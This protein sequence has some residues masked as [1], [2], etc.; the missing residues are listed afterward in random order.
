MIVGVVFPVFSSYRAYE[1]YSRVAKRIAASQFRVGGV[2]VPIGQLLNVEALAEDQRQLQRLMIS[3]QKWFI[4]WVVYATIE[5]AEAVLF[6]PTLIPL[7][8]LFR[9]VVH[10]WLVVPMALAGGSEDVDK[11]FDDTEAWVEFTQLGPG[12]V[13]FGYIKPII[14]DFLDKWQ[15]E[16]PMAQVAEFVKR[17]TPDKPEE[18]K[19]SGVSIRETVDASYVMVNNL[20]DRL[21]GETTTVVDEPNNNENHDVDDAKETDTLLPDTKAGKKKKG[22][23]FW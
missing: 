6:L 21:V 18:S 7:Y 4:Y 9:L 13:Y 17:Q 10:L 3:I 2:T 8:S 12:L 16:L 15:V 11:L 14:A 5:T 23:G 22:W 19:S 20:R 1:G